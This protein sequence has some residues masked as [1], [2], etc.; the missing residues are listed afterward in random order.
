MVSRIVLP[1][2]RERADGAPGGAARRG[3]EAGRRL[4][5]EDELRVADEREREVQ[6]ARLA[7]GQLR[8]TRTSALSCRPTSSMTSSTSR[9]R[10]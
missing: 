8:A 9:G 5:E 2:S 1:R 4:V 6:A 7:A 10:G 3:V